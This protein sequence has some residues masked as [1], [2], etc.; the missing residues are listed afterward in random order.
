[1]DSK[2]TGDVLRVVGRRIVHKKHEKI[3]VPLYALLILKYFSVGHIS[4]KMAHQRLKEYHLPR[5]EHASPP[6]IRLQPA[7]H[8]L[9]APASNWSL[10]LVPI[11]EPGNASPGYSEPLVELLQLLRRISPLVK[12]FSGKQH[13][14]HIPIVLYGQEKL[15]IFQVHA[16]FRM[17]IYLSCFYG[18]IEEI[19]EFIVR[20]GRG[21]R[22]ISCALIF[23]FNGN[24][25]RG[26]ASLSQGWCVV[27][28]TYDAAGAD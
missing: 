4:H 27:A 7:T 21:R 25:F 9:L 23:I 3:E 16:D 1:M 18:I 6:M 2:R 24:C 22:R 19:L 20:R 8:L 17:V 10:Y 14:F 5:S 13:G 15:L 26:K 11:T 28:T 12:E